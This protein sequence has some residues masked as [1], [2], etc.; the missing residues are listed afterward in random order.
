MLHQASVS[1][2]I[3]D[4][5]TRTKQI[6]SHH[7]APLSAFREDRLLRDSMSRRCRLICDLFE[8]WLTAKRRFD[9]RRW[10]VQGSKFEALHD[11]PKGLEHLAR[12]C[13]LAT[14]EVYFVCSCRVVKVSPG[15]VLLMARREIY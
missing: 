10:C 15:L 11:K 7:D 1:D 4:R 6:C 12:L 3:M 2:L 14:K 13:T 8:D 9:D 5:F